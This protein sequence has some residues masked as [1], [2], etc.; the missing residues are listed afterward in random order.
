MR[1]M[2]L[3]NSLFIYFVC[4]VYIYIYIYIFKYQVSNLVKIG[5]SQHNLGPN[6]K[7]IMWSL[8]C[9]NINK[10]KLF[11]TNQIKVNLIH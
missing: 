8:L 11:N 5:A 2:H 6:A 3:K 7:K 9:V 1:H 10:I 4:V